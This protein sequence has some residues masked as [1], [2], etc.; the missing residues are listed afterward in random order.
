MS[1][2]TRFP[3]YFILPDLQLSGRIH[4]NLRHHFLTRRVHRIILRFVDQRFGHKRLIPASVTKS[5]R[6][7]HRIISFKKN[8]YPEGFTATLSESKFFNLWIVLTSPTQQGTSMS[9]PLRIYPT[10]DTNGS[11]FFSRKD[12][13][14]LFCFF[15]IFWHPSH[16]QPTAAPAISASAN[17]IVGLL[18]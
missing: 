5:L 14:F 11:A 10:C 12:K 17:G 16:T 15:N 18:V 7:T 2:H 13:V 1:Y 4:L 3:M 8:L 6:E 9:Y